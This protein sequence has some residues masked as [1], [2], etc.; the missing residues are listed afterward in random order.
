MIYAFHAGSS[1]ATA[2]PKFTE[3]QALDFLESLVDSLISLR[4]NSNFTAA[5]MFLSLPDIFV[6]PNS[7]TAPAIKPPILTYKQEVSIQKV[8]QKSVLS[9]L[10]KYPPEMWKNCSG[11]TEQSM[12]WPLGLIFY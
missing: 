10:C 12:V 8:T 9:S 7:L 4:Q 1:L 3:Q 5:P 6:H 2:K 11:V